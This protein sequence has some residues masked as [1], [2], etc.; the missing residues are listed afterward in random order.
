MRGG[1][2]PKLAQ[3]CTEF[4]TLIEPSVT[5]LHAGASTHVD[6]L[7]AS[8]ALDHC[9]LAWTTAPPFLVVVLARAQL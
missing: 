7:R 2:H 3:L 9:V 8:K 5:H 4:P 1:K 6:T